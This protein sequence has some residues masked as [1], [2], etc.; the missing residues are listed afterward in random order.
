MRGSV[1]LA[2]STVRPHTLDRP[3]ALDFLESCR[4]ELAE[5]VPSNEAFLTCGL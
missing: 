1:E 3:P 4:V 5:E 2:L